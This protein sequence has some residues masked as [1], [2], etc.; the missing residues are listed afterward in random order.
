AD[1]HRAVVDLRHFLLEELDEQRRV[2]ARQHDL[3]ALGGAVD[4]ADDRADAVADGVVLRARLFLARQLGFNPPELHDDVAVLEALDH[5]AHDFPDAVAVL[6]VDVVALGLADLLEDHLLRGLG[7]DAPEI[8]GRPRELDLHVDFR[9]LAI[10]L[11]RFGERDLVGRIGHFLDDALDGAELDLSGFRVELGAQR[12]VLV[13][14]ARG[15]LDGVLHGGNDDFRLDALFL[16]D[17]VDLLQQRILHVSYQL[18]VPSFQLKFNIQAGALDPVE[19]HPV[20]SSSFFEDHGTRL[21]PLDP[22]RA[23]PLAV[24]RFRRDDPRDPSR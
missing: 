3:G 17:G 19:R 8:L 4:A 24:D 11:L 15:R 1:D 7:G 9:F 12:L 23:R 13:P 21:D 2:G 5:A 20:R 18:P 6:G 10:E 14:L 22:S 16:G